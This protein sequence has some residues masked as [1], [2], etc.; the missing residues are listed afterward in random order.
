MIIR[1]FHRLLQYLIDIEGKTK[2]S[3]LLIGKVGRGLDILVA[4]SVKNW[5][6]IYCYDHNG[7]YED[8]LNQFFPDLNIKFSISSTLN[9]DHS[10]CRNPYV[11]ILNHA[12]ID[13]IGLQRFQENPIMIEL[14]I[15]GKKFRER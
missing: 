13:R 10:Q 1:I 8:L 11:M 5:N 9:Y 12:L 4:L 7:R 3:E 2:V 6:K 14:L 15:D